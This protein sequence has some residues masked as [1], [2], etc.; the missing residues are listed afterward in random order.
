MSNIFI[1][2]IIIALV[3]V[4]PILIIW[5]LNTL[6]PSLAIAYGVAEW[7]AVVILSGALKSTVKVNS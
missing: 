6:F 4:G 1:N 2:I 5:A 3:I 7:F